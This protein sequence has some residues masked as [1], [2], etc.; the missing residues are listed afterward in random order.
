MA[1]HAD[2]LLGLLPPVSYDPQAPGVRAS[3]TADGLAL[4]RAHANAAKALG[5]LT[6]FDDLAWLEDYERVYGLP[7]PCV[8]GER[9]MRER[10]AAVAAALLE[11]GGGSRAY[12]RRLALAFGF[13]IEVEEY[14][15][16]TCES[17]C[18]APLCDEPWRW[19]WTVRAPET[20]VHE[21]SCMSGCSEPL[22]TWGNE[23]L[24]CIIRQA[25]LAHTHVLFAY[26]G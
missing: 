12:Y 13:Q 25:N 2:L 21:F 1:G 23:L 9:T 15:I 5:P 24:E 20:T 19:I 8:F 26:G 4:D 22:A 17:S 10:V 7:G 14:D 3:C 18:V 11:R 16:H 6:P